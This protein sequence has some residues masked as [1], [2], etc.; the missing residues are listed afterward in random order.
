MHAL[1][2]NPC[3]IF[4]EIINLSINQFYLKICDNIWKF[5]VQ[6]KD[7]VIEKILLLFSKRPKRTKD[8]IMKN[9]M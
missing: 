9:S 1:A 2:F 4:D 6:N 5:K 7:K 8:K 3:Y